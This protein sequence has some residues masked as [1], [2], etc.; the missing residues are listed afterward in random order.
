MEL[1]WIHTK[2]LCQSFPPTD[3]SELNKLMAWELLLLF[4]Q[5]ALDWF[6][7][8]CNTNMLNSKQCQRNTHFN[9]PWKLQNVFFLCLKLKEVSNTVVFLIC[10]FWFLS[11]LAKTHPVTCRKTEFICSATYPANSVLHT[12]INMLMLLYTEDASLLYLS[13][14]SLK[15]ICM[16]T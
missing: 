9:S 3:P 4:C 7:K 1:W 2:C 14:M 6:V 13:A 12:K 10:W 11:R 15:V 16:E 8:F 5:T